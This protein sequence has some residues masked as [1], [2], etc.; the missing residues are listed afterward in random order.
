MGQELVKYSGAAELVES[1]DHRIVVNAPTAN[2][3]R[4]RQM[5]QGGVSPEQSRC[6]HPPEMLN[7]HA[8]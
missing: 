7:E 8:E 1:S 6:Y 3:Q 2:Q 5:L 4:L